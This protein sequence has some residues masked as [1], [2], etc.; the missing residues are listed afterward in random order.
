MIQVQFGCINFFN[1]TNF[2]SGSWSLLGSRFDGSTNDRIG[3]VV[4]LND[5]GNRIAFS[6][7]NIQD[8]NHG[9]VQIYIDW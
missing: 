8:I 6:S 2:T 9:E 7:K 1:G 5:Y 4:S 3:N